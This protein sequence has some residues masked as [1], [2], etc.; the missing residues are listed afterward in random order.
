MKSLDLHRRSF[1]LTPRQVTFLEAE[2]A[3]TGVVM[4]EV[5]RRILDDWWDRQ[6]LKVPR[7]RTRKRPPT[8]QSQIALEGSP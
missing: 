3:R 1:S 2:V 7:N 8:E 6:E 5:V 4:S